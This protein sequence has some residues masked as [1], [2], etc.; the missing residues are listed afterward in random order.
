MHK[1]IFL[2]SYSRH[3]GRI[4]VASLISITDLLQP[5]PPIQNAIL[6]QW[7]LGERG[8]LALTEWNRCIC[9]CST[10]S[11]PFLLVNR[12]YTNGITICRCEKSLRNLKGNFWKSE[13]KQSGVRFK[14][15]SECL[16]HFNYFE[17]IRIV[18]F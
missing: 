2:K 16:Q 12:N 10:V 11:A 6:L 7:W 14:R 18:C 8:V 4:L 17:G 5:P 15:R 9:C 3:L 1:V 13:I